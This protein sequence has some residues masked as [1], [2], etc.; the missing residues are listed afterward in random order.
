[1]NSPICQIKGCIVW[2]KCWLV[3][4]TFWLHFPALRSCPSLLAVL[5]QRCQR[6]R[7]T[8]TCLASVHVFTKWFLIKKKTVVVHSFTNSLLSSSF[9]FW[10]LRPVEFLVC[11]NE[12]LP[13][14]PY[15]GGME[16]GGGVFSPFFFLSVASFAKVSFRLTN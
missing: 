11:Q 15:I 9:L 2:L 7:F 12:K 4:D 14:A 8:F 13:P 6:E 1:M 16:L 3:G 10:V 5:G